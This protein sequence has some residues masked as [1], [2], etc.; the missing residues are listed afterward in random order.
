MKNQDYRLKYNDLKLKF[1]DAVDVSFRLGFE[2]G[3][4][5]AQVQQA[6]Q[7]QADAQAAQQAA[8]GQQPGAPGEE[9]PNA[10]MEAGSDGSELDQHIG[11]LE[12]ML[13]K[14]EVGS[15]EYMDFKKS[16]DGIK[17]YQAEIKQKHDLKKSEMAIS[18]INKALKSPFTFSKAATKNLSEPA[19]KALTMQEQI[20][21]DFM[22]SFDEEK[23]KASQSVTKAIDLAQILKDK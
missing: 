7:Q 5:Q 23:E 13:Q 4:Q 18:S 3:A 17:S 6:Q 1:L 12:S 15:L 20:V 14:T 19:K 16:L 2:Q 9:D 21:D 10:Q 22:K 11:K 8:A